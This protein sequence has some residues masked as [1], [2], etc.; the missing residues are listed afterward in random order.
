MNPYEKLS[1]N[2]GI[3]HIPSGERFIIDNISARKT[4]PY[5][6]DTPEDHIFITKF[7]NGQKFIDCA[8]VETIV[9]WQT[10]IHQLNE[11][12][13]DSTPF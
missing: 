13:E 7:I 11:L 5:P 6:K 8:H 1:I 3:M 12:Y 9:E 10:D 4:W 2:I